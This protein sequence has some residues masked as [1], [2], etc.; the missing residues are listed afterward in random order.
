M[1]AYGVE[2]RQRVLD[3]CDNGMTEIATA[4]KWKV[5]QSF[6]AKIKKQRRDPGSIELK[7]P[8]TGPKHVTKNT[9]EPHQELLKI[10]VA[11]TPDATLAEIQEQLPIQVSN[12]A[13]HVELVKLKLIYKKKQLHASEQHREDVAQKRQEWKVMQ[14]GL[15]PKK[16]VFIDETGA[17]TNMVR[18]YGRAPIGENWKASTSRGC[19]P[20]DSRESSQLTLG[21]CGIRHNKIVAPHVVAGAMTK[22]RF[23]EYVQKVL[24]KTLRKGDI[25]VM[26][27][28]SSHKEAEVQKLIESK[29]ATIMYLPPYSPDLNPIELLFSKLK[30]E[31]RKRKI[32]D[33]ES[34]QQ[35]LLE[36]GKLFTKQQCKNY[37]KHAGYGRMALPFALLRK[38]AKGITQK[39]RAA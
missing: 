5:S 30:S 19:Q 38:A 8:K 11:K 29:G 36:S 17:K 12:R 1:K 10:I 28:L 9:L 16:L 2:L 22:V 4:N 6:I 24:L 37:F 26:D 18:K 13:I 20:P 35:F 21:V 14:M 25:V 34:L 33:V 39:V 31:L 7:I 32:R 27:N 23:V 15:N 3:D